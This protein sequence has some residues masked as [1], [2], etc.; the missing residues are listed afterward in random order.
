MCVH[1][2]RFVLITSTKWPEDDQ[3]IQ[4]FSLEF[5][6]GWQPPEVSA[7]ARQNDPQPALYEVNHHPKHSV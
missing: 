2:I 6:D 4:P 5:A 7:S 1:L 3:H